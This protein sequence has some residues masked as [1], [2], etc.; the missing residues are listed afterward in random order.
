MEAALPNNSAPLEFKVWFWF[1]T[2]EG[3]QTSDEGEIPKMYCKADWM[4][5]LIL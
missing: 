5:L 2:M 4:A 3:E 1:C